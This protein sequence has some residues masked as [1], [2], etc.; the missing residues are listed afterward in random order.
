MGWKAPVES[1]NFKT[2][3]FE[4]QNWMRKACSISCFSEE[5]FISERDSATST[6][7]HHTVF[8][9]LFLDVSTGWSSCRMWVQYS[10]TSG[11]ILQ[12]I[13]VEHWRDSIFTGC[14]QS[15]GIP[16]HPRQLEMGYIHSFIINFQAKKISQV[17]LQP[18]KISADA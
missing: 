7:I 6:R 16:S 1:N 15:K 17:K 12:K 10:N 5:Y 11:A 2:R 13:K 4:M 9:L 14:A 8:H 18:M 3:G